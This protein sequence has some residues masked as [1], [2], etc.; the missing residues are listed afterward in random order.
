MFLLFAHFVER[1]GVLHSAEQDKLTVFS[2]TEPHAFAWMATLAPSPFIKPFPDS[3]LMEDLLCSHT[4]HFLLGML[5]LLLQKGPPIDAL[6]IDTI[7][8]TTLDLAL[9]CALSCAGAGCYWVPV[10]MSS[11][12][13]CCWWRM[14]PEG[15]GLKCW[16]VGGME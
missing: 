7:V 10:G 4:T 2:P 1:H 3:I 13:E 8:D 14:M 5:R 12:K 15:N 6:G 9:S 16:E 11:V